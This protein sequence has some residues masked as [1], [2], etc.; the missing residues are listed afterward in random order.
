MDPI[1]ELEWLLEVAPECHRDDDGMASMER[2]IATSIEHLDCVSGA[3]VLKSGVSMCVRGSSAEALG[4]DLLSL[5]RL[6]RALIDGI[7]SSDAAELERHLPPL[8]SSWTAR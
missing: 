1:N 5:R 2:L 8:P 3:L 4:R 7:G 6:E